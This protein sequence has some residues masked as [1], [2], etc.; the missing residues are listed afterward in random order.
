MSLTFDQLNNFKETKKYLILAS[1]K[2]DDVTDSNIRLF[3]TI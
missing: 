2:S 3:I 1:V